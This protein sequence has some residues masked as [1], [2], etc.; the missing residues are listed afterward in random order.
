MK[1]A[2]VIIAQ[3]KTAGGTT[4]NPLLGSRTLMPIFGMF[5]RRKPLEGLGVDNEC[6]LGLWLKIYGCALFAVLTTCRIIL[7]VRSFTSLR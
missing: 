6:I 4:K 1:T 5:T 3:L 2:F 7:S